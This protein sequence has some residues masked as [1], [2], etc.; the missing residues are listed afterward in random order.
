MVAAGAAARMPWLERAV[1]LGV[2]AG[3]WG[4]RFTQA[5]VRNGETV[6][7]S[8]SVVPVTV[9]ATFERRFGRVVPYAGAALGAAFTQTGVR[10]PTVGDVKKHDAALGA[11]LM[12]GAGAD[13]GP[14]RAGI[15]LGYFGSGVDNDIVSGNCGGW[16]LTAGYQLDL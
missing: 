4:N 11:A 7:T 12:G 5:D 16:Q 2:E 1:A 6:Q 14:G 10:S 15:E 13:V 9:R 3:Y 8:L